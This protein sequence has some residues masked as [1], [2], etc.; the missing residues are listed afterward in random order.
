[1]S[2]LLHHHC[3]YLSQFNE[4][5]STPKYGIEQHSK[6]YL[7]LCLF[8]DDNEQGNSDEVKRNPG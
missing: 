3:C 4:V 1:M 6:G 2:R 7:D 8:H 5:D